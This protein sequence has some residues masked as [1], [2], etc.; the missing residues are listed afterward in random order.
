LAEAREKSRDA[1]KIAKDGG[2]PIAARKGSVD[3]LTFEEA[4]RKVHGEQ[5]VK[6]GRNEKYRA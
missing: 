1:R 5:I 6:R 3:C 4:A 2:D